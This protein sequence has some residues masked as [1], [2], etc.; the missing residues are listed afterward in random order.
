MQKSPCSTQKLQKLF[1]RNKNRHGSVAR[2]GGGPIIF[3]SHAFAQPEHG[4]STD[5][6]QKLLLA[7][8]GRQQHPNLATLH[9]VNARC[10]RTLLE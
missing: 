1:A 5:D 4:S 10:L 6:F 8:T 7:L 3:P 2:F 9:Q